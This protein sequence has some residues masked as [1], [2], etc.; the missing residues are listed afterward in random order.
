M[1][2]ETK[3]LEATVQLLQER[4][5]PMSITSRDI[6]GRAGV[7]PALINYYYGSKNTLLMKSIYEIMET[8]KESVVSEMELP[9]KERLR[10]YLICMGDDMIRY[11]K[12][13]RVVVPDVLL[14]M[15]LGDEEVLKMV[16]EHYSGR[17]PE[18][19]CRLKALMLIDTLM[20]LFYRKAEAGEYLGLDLSDP[21]EV[22]RWTSD[23]VDSILD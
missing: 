12:L 18:T 4:E 13:V 19:E 11:E 14:S 23:V 9:A 1:S 22:K 6:G 15:P 16:M 7:N 2:K 21:E 10:K 5:D 3:L 8:T 17:I 20:I